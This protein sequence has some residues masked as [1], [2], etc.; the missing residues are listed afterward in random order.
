MPLI[1]HELIQ[2]FCCCC[3]RYNYLN[4]PSFHSNL[5]WLIF[6]SDTGVFSYF[7]SLISWELFSSLSLVELPISYLFF[8]ILG[9]KPME[10]FWKKDESLTRIM[11]NCL[12]SRKRVPYYTE[13]Q[14][15]ILVMF[16]FLIWWLRI[17][18]LIIDC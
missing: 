2:F 4:L 13:W 16:S 10:L 17:W 18:E 12:N 6:W 11:Y 15:N 9:K 7:F 5:N 1:L 8:F 14:F 3:W